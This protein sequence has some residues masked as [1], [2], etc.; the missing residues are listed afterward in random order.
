[1]V[2]IRIP[3]SPR[4]RRALEMLAGAGE[5]GLPGAA[6]MASGF[7]TEMLESLVRVGLAV[8]TPALDG[9]PASL[10]ITEVGK[11]TLGLRG[12]A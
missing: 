11:H 7:P 2:M 3:L 8:P 10:R 9:E 4:W 1:M 6:L 12:L 5:C